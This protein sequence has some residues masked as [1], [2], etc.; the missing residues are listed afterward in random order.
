MDSIRLIGGTITD[1]GGD[2]NHR[3]FIGDS[4]GSRDRLGNGI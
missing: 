2:F 4:F 1:G 3:G